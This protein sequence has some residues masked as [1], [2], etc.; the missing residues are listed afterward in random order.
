[1][2]LS[3]YVLQCEVSAYA[4]Q[5][6][7]M[8]YLVCTAGV[9]CRYALYRA[10]HYNTTGMAYLVCTTGVHYRYALYRAIHYNTT[11]MHCTVLY[12]TIHNYSVSCT[13][14]T[15]HNYTVVQVSSN[16]L[17]CEYDVMDVTKLLFQTQQN[18]RSFP[19]SNVAFCL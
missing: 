12:I 14:I 1:M 19:V 4:L 10:V 9:H 6:W 17:Y 3:F 11:G 8:A 7:H 18:P 13:H 15:T 2:S 16:A 5:V